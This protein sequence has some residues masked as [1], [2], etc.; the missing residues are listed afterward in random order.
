MHPLVRAV[1]AAGWVLRRIGADKY[2]V[3]CPWEA[4]HTQGSAG[5]T[6]TVIWG[7]GNFFC[8]HAHC[9]GTEIVTGVVAQGSAAIP[10]LLGEAS[11]LIVLAGL[12]WGVG[13]LAIL[14][15]DVGHDVRAAR[16]LLARARRTPSLHQRPRRRALPS[17]RTGLCGHSAAAGT[18]VAHELG[19]AVHS[20]PRMHAMLFTLAI[21]LFVLWA[22]GF[23]AFHVGG[24]L[25]HL[26]LV[27]ALIVIVYRLVTGRR[28]VV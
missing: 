23:F 4:E 10:T 6:S 12:L 1:E 22:L 18:T 9:A 11:R 13:D 2:A 27:L 3:R 28:P 15:I 17:R 7:N 5:D 14:L 19:S 24:G 25:I 21:V 8:S 20:Y 16:I 26:L